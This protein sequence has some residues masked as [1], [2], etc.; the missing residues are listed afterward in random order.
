MLTKPNVLALKEISHRRILTPKD[1]IAYLMQKGC[2]R[3]SNITIVKSKL[4]KCDVCGKHSD[5]MYGLSVY[6]SVWDEWAV[7]FTF[8]SDRCYPNLKTAIT[9]LDEATIGAI[10]STPIPSFSVLKCPMCTFSVMYA[11]NQDSVV[12]GHCKTNIAI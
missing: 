6:N 1:T 12:C 4:K 8:C 11:P 2:Y 3:L 9:V 5:D 7:E 10:V